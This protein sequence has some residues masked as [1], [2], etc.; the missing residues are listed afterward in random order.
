MEPFDPQAKTRHE[1]MESRS[2][3]FIA[4]DWRAAKG[5]FAQPPLTSGS[6][7]LSVSSVRSTPILVVER[8]TRCAGER[9]NHRHDEPNCLRSRA[10]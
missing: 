2:R 3:Q 1:L 6:G 7:T 5:H 8:S 10:S 9:G 4:L